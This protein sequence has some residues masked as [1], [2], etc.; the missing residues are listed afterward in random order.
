MLSL[1]IAAVSA[2]LAFGFAGAANAAFPIYPLIGT[3]NPA[4]YDFNAM[5]NGTLIGYFAGSDAGDDSDFTVTIDGMGG[6]AHIGPNHST[7][8]G[9]SF[10]FGAVTA[11]QAILLTLH[12]L[13]TGVDISSTPA[14]NAGGFQAVYATAYAGGDA[15]IPAGIFVTFEDRGATGDRDYNDYSFVFTNLS[16]TTFNG[17]VPEPATWA[18]M[19]MGFT[20]MGA[21]IRRRRTALARV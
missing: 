9:T 6:L 11:G 12:D 16:T 2:A 18:M 15:G 14:L 3:E 13:T 10:N 5:S 7:A 1:R 19:I 4:V 17:G 21:V 20:G 8:V